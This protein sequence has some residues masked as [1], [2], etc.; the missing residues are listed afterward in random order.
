MTEVQRMIL[1]RV[2]SQELGKQERWMRKE[3]E[4]FG[5][6]GSD[7]KSLKKEIENFMEEEGIEFREDFYLEEVER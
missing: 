6:D 4:Q 5:T 7:R 3:K 1:S 2:L